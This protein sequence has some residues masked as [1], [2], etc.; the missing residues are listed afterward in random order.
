MDKSDFIKFA[1]RYYAWICG[2]EQAA[3]RL[4]DMVNQK[5]DRVL[6]YGFHLKMVASYVSRYGYY[7]AD[8][9]LDILVLYASAYLHDTIEDARMSYNDVHRFLA[10]YVGENPLFSAEVAS[11]LCEL[12]P[13]IVYALTNEK[14]RSRNER[15]NE[16]YYKG[17]RETRLASFV[18]MCDRLAN[19]RYTTL[20]FF[21]G[22]MLQVYRSEHAD[23][24][25]SI[26]EGAVTPVPTLM[27]QEA[28]ELLNSEAY[29]FDF[30]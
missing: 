6:P 20:F 21:A 13:E 17:I 24:I 11:Q 10:D 29:V 16:L 18:K 30:N 26:N 19:I 7:V 4:H 1:S 3:F 14:G 2:L 8:N 28:E 15:A 22:R 25:R 23:F 9:E 12:V 27:I 5:Y